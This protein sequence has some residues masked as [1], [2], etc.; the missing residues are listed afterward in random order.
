MDKKIK[1]GILN[2]APFF[3]F[4]IAFVLTLFYEFFSEYYYACRTHQYQ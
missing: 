1:G 2:A 3:T 4:A